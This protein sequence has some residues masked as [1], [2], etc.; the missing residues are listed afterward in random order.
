MINLGRCLVYL[1]SHHE[2]VSL[3][4]WGCFLHDGRP[5][6]FDPE[7]EAFYSRS[8]G[9]LFRP[10]GTPAPADE[11][12]GSTQQLLID[13]IG[14][15]RKVDA[16]EAERLYWEAF[17]FHQEEL[18]SKGQTTLSGIG[19]LKLGA[20]G[21]SLESSVF[22]TGGSQHSVRELPILA[23]IQTQEENALNHEVEF[24]SNE[25]RGGARYGWIVAA[26]ILLLGV[27]F[28]AVKP[29]EVFHFL[30]ARGVEMPILARLAGDSPALNA[31]AENRNAVVSEDPID[32]VDTTL[33]ADS[34][35]KES[36][37]LASDSLAQLAAG[38][39]IVL[40]E[41]E[42][43]PRVSYEIIVGSFRS[44]E[45][46]NSFVEEMAQKSIKVW[47]IDSRMPENRK[48]V[49]CASFPTEAEAYRALKEIQR[50]IEPGAWVARVER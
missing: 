9:I 17:D 21:M 50:T 13:Y 4:G 29:A 6:Y 38:E 18:E 19:L 15:Q 48:K 30:S 10:E 41:D 2:K 8:Y 20:D 28:V 45:Q 12:V 36:A 26:S 32:L 37:G 1:L 24:E 27:A 23:P 16:E 3:A 47:A 40:M 5:A 7:E 11:I 43:Q 42:N 14:A 49:S 31:D 46:A 44:M 25:R 22:S 34:V 33:G 39:E 35:L